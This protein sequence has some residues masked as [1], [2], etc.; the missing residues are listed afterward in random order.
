MH[1][2][3]SGHRDRPGGVGGGA[4]IGAEPVQVDAEGGPGHR[5]ELLAGDEPAASTQ[6]D[7]LTDRMSVAGDGERLTALYGIHD[8]D[9]LRR[10]RWVI[11]G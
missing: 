4:L 8:L 3:V 10:S 5:G 1:R 2:V 9:R 6:R 7:E 11:S